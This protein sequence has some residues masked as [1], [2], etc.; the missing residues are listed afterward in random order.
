MDTPSLVIV[1]APHFFSRTTLRPLGPRVTL[2][3]SARVFIPCS[4][5]RRASSSKAMSFAIRVVPPRESK[6]A[7]GGAR[8]GRDPLTRLTSPGGRAPHLTGQDCHSHE[9]SANDI[10]GTLSPPVQTPRP[11]ARPP[12]RTEA[13]PTPPARRSRLSP[14]PHAGTQHPGGGFTHRPIRNPFVTFGSA[15][16]AQPL[17]ADLAGGGVAGRLVEALGAGLAAQ[18]DDA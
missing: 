4:R 11:G 15:N 13:A 9:E 1:G 12:R 2:T 17:L 18:T 3:A 6:G 8:D 10:I 16:G 5:P 7:T 14:S